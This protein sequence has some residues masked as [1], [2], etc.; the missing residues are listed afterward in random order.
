MTKPKP[1]TLPKTGGRHIR[2]PKSGRLKVS[3]K[4][5]ED[6]PPGKPVKTP[7][8]KETSTPKGDDA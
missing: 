2:D 4:P 6:P 1:K 5:T 8:Q 3:Q 7:P